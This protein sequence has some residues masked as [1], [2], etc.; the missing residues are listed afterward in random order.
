MRYTYSKSFF[1]L[2]AALSLLLRGAFCRSREW[3][4]FLVVMHG[5]LIEMASLAEHIFQERIGFSGC[6]IWAQYLQFSDS[7]VLTSVVVHRLSC[8]QA[9]GIFPNQGLNSCLLQ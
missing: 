1:F 2:P 4:C 5:L 3:G 6:D 8:S 9:C 7:R